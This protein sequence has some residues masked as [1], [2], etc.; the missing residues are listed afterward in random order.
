M[1]KD[2]S[3]IFGLFTLIILLL[4]FGGGL[5]TSS[6]LKTNAPQNIPKS[7]DQKVIPVSIK[8]LTV[9]A[10]LAVNQEERKNGLSGRDSLPFDQGMLFIFEKEGQYTFWMKEMRFAIDIIWIDEKKTIVDIAKNVPPELGEKDRELMIYRPRANAK[11]VLEINAGLSDL[12]NL[13]V[14]DKVDFKL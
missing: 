2:L 10:Q 4:L 11:Y 7:Q 5:T 13:E 9:S 3:I 12:N 14:S 8:N 6:F 1:K